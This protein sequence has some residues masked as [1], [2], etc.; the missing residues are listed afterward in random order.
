MIGGSGHSLVAEVSVDLNKETKR[1][2][3]GKLETYA[4]IPSSRFHSIKRISEP[5]SARTFEQACKFGDDYDSIISLFSNP[6]SVR[7]W[8]DDLIGKISAIRIVQEKPD[9]TSI[10]RKTLVEQVKDRLRRPEDYRSEDIVKEYFAKVGANKGNPR[11]CLWSTAMIEAGFASGQDISITFQRT[12]GSSPLKP[13]Y[14]IEIGASKIS[15][16]RKVSKVMNHGKPLPVIDIKTTRKIQLDKWVEVGDKV[17]VTIR[18]G[19]ITIEKEVK[20]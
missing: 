19:R 8:G 17:L 18:P 20:S 9:G 10:P 6:H 12:Y 2:R 1:S 16:G 14:Q 15:T 5:C 4:V 3:D 7:Q 13:E 11:V